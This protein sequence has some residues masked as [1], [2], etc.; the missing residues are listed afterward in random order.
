MQPLTRL[1][2]NVPTSLLTENLQVELAFRKFDLDKD[3]F[4]SWEEFSQVFN[5]TFYVK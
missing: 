4:L 5:S 1:T 3:G 2:L